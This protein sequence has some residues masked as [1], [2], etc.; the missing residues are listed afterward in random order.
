VRDGNT[1]FMYLE[2]LLASVQ[3]FEE[4]AGGTCIAAYLAHQE[5]PSASRSGHDLLINDLYFVAEALSSE[6]ISIHVSCPA[7]KCRATPGNAAC[8]C[9]AGFGTT[10]SGVT[11]T[12]CVSGKY[13]ISAGNTDC[14]ACDENVS[15]CGSTFLLS[16]LPSKVSI[17]DARH[18]SNANIVPSSSVGIPDLSGTAGMTW[19]LGAG[20]ISYETVD[21]IP[22]WNM[23]GGYLET[24][25]RT[26]HGDSY[27]IFY[28]WK[29]KV[30][31]GAGPH[32]S[33]HRGIE[34][35]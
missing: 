14:T 10:D 1:L 3:E 22:C 5:Y 29:P 28:Y 27:T 19:K 25:T 26:K 20:A 7:G 23:S 13:K 31:N 9:C 33:L 34:V 6:T 4:Y 30:I 21:G 24:T 16:E 18:A 12:A 11:C 17:L 32:L 2:G 35:S 15:G 8:T